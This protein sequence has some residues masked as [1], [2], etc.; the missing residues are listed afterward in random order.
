MSAP[1]SSKRRAICSFPQ[2]AAECSGVAPLGSTPAMLALCSRRIL[3]SSTRLKGA[4]KSSG[5]HRPKYG[6]SMSTPRLS[7]SS[8]SSRLPSTQA[9]CRSV[10]PFT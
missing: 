9:M 4:A 1:C 10:S 7:V 6:E 2:H 3:A 5:L 8:S